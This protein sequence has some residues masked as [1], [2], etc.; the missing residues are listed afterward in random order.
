[1]SWH[2]TQS[3]T[4]P[5]QVMGRTIVRFFRILDVIT[6]SCRLTHSDAEHMMIDLSHCQFGRSP[7]AP[8]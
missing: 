4:I 8:R 7:R 5:Y 6:R 3:D 2:A 1:M